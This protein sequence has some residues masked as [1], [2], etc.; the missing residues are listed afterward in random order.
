MTESVSA[1]QRRP[2][3]ARTGQGWCL[4]PVRGFGG[5]LMERQF[6]CWERNLEHPS[7]NPLIGSSFE[8]QRNRCTDVGFTCDRLDVDPLSVSLW[9]FVMLFDLRQRAAAL[10]RQL[11]HL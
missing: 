11:W 7:V 5:R 8:C 4:S 2:K 3:R 6:W 1:R 9:G 10:K